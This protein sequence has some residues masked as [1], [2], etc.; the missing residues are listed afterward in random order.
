VPIWAW[1]AD[2][3]SETCIPSTVEECI[4]YC[5]RMSGMATRNA[6]YDLKTPF[7]AY[8][9]KVLLERETDINLYIIE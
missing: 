6:T 8:A 9:P 2:V 3:G 5:G 1:D 4:G 7:V